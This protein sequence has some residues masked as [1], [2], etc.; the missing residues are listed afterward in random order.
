MNWSPPMYFILYIG[1]V[2]V[3]IQFEFR[4]VWEEEKKASFYRIN[5]KLVYF[6]LHGI[7]FCYNSRMKKVES[8]YFHYKNEMCDRR[9]E[10]NEC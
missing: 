9:K 2:V 4:N 6:Y 7:V 8:V 3:F 10:R 1:F 5:M